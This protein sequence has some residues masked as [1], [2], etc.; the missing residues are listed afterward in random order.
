MGPRENRSARRGDVGARSGSSRCRLRRVHGCGPGR[1]RVPRRRRPLPQSSIAEAIGLFDQALV[2]AEGSGERTDRLRSD[3]F[4]WRSR[5]HRRHRDW[6]A[7]AED[8]ERALELADASSDSRRAADALFQASL[9]AQRQG[10]WVLARTYAERSRDALRGARR[11]GDGGAAAEQP[12]WTEPSPRQRR[13]V[14]RSP[15][16]RPSRSS[17]TSISPSTQATSARRSP[18]FASTSARPSSRRRRRARR[19]S[20]W[21]SAPTTCRRWEPPSSRSVARSRSRAG[22]RRRSSGSCGPKRLPSGPAPR[23]IAA[24]PGSPAAIS[25]AVAA[26]TPSR[27]VCTGARLARS[28]TPRSS[29]ASRARKRSPGAVR[30]ETARV[31]GSSR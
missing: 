23:A 4:H 16:A 14:D 11:P 20:S 13:P 27:P 30:R 25:R 24:P 29:A 3:I 18:R 9:V 5:C 10:R 7:A 28:R 26:M 15:R 12:R 31:L 8:I 1:G 6:V 19:S 2:L 22:S 17:S 21:V